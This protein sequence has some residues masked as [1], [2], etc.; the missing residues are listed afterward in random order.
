MAIGVTK[1]QNIAFNKARNLIF[2]EGS[3]LCYNYKTQQWTECPAYAG[4][5]F[6][7]YNSKLV[8]IGV[9]R[10]S[11]GSVSITV[12][13]TGTVAQTATIT[14]GAIDPNTG[15]RG[16][17]TGVRPIANGGTY[18][19]RVGVQDDIDAAVTWSA[20]TVVNTRS[21]M[22]NF[23]S[24]GRYVRVETVITGGFTTA[25]G[26]DVEFVAQGSV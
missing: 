9:I 11:A 26:A 25:M 23:R 4:L 10:Y 21:N 13:N 1:Q 22:A 8:S 16:V 17:V 19:V 6:Y 20:S 7:S 3:E 15:G 12:G 24:E 2:F 5:G 14:T 18:A